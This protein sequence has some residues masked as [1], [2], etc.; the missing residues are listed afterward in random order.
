M[1]L[2]ERKTGQAVFYHH[3]GVQAGVTTN[4]AKKRVL[5]DVANAGAS[6][7]MFLSALTDLIGEDDVLLP[8]AASLLIYD[9]SFRLSVTSR[10]HSGY[11]GRQLQITRNP[12]IRLNPDSMMEVLMAVAEEIELAPRAKNLAK[13]ALTIIFQAESR[14]HNKPISELHLHETGTIDTVLDLVGTAY[15]LERAGLLEDAEF[16]S[17]RVAVGSGTI[18]TEHGDLEVPGP[19]VAEILVAHDMLFHNGEARTEVLT[20]TGAALLA[21]I[22][23]VYVDAYDGFVAQNQGIGF[24]TRDLGAIPNMMRIVVGELVVQEEKKP[25]SPPK[26]ESKRA[27]AKEAKA[28][29]DSKSKAEERSEVLDEWSADEVVVIETN[30]DDVD[31]ETLGSLFDTLLVEGLAYDVVVIPA[32]GKKSRPCFLV[33]VIAA[34]TGLKSVA[35]VMM[36]HLGTTGIRYSTWQRLKAARETI[37]CGLNIDDKEY[38][39]RVKVSRTTDG[40]I[41]SIKPEDDDVERVSRETGIPIRELKPRIAMQAHAVTE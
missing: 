17:T 38:M 37:V 3:G 31:G 9:P 12:A 4:L 22:T 8:V 19:A 1:S 35:E 32:L 7:D 16:V 27:L 24:G 13:E 40:S 36:R 6:G 39:V 41:I 14:V 15:L 18:A 5:I 30:V 26:E 25:V 23:K 10:S 21:A 2:F 34:K 20:P 11:T 28:P 33:K 29:P